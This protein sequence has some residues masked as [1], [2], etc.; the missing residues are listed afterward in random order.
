MTYQNWSE[1]E[2]YH[3]DIEHIVEKNNYVSDAL[4]RINISD[5]KESTVEMHKLMQYRTVKMK[6]K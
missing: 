5:L 6:N 3:F 4:S 2:E 1:L